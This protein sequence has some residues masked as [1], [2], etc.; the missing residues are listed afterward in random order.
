MEVIPRIGDIVDF[1]DGADEHIFVVDRVVH[2]Y[3]DHRLQMVTFQAGSGRTGNDES[4]RQVSR[5]A[6]SSMEH[7]A[8]WYLFSD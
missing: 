1:R 4:R 3:E 5:N 8:D 6:G 7:S 2:V